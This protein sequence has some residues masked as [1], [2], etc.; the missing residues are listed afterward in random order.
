MRIGVFNIGIC[1]IRSIL[2]TM[3]FLGFSAEEIT[4]QQDLSSYDKII[5]PGVG[6]FAFAVARLEEIDAIGPIKEYCE[7]GGHYLGI[8]LGMQILGE[9]G[10]EGGETRGL[11]LIP[12]ETVKLQ[13][14]TKKER[15]PHNGWNE[16]RIIRKDDPLFTGIPDG[17]DFYFNHSYALMPAGSPIIAKTPYCEEIVSAVRTQNTWGVQFHPEKS[18]WHGMQLIKNFLQCAC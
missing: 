9:K 8:C 14:V 18:Q 3:E 6:S 2:N 10:S 7:K 12:G 1:N 13:P 16:V 11:G 5:F 17:A 15:V 4:G